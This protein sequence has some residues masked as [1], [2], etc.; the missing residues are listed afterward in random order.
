MEPPFDA[1]ASPSRVALL[2]ALLLTVS[3]AHAQAP[4][5]GHFRTYGGIDLGAPALKDITE[6]ESAVRFTDPADVKSRRAATLSDRTLEQL[7]LRN[8]AI[9]SYTKGFLRRQDFGPRAP[10]KAFAELPYLTNTQF[11]ISRRIRYDERD[12]KQ[13]GW[14]AYL[15][16][17][18]ATDTC[19][20]FNAYLGDSLRFDQQVHG[21][22]C[23]PAASRSAA[24]LEREMLTLLSH[25]RFAQ[26]MNASSF[27]VSLEIPETALAAPAPAAPPTPSATAGP[28]PP[29]PAAAERL[30]A[31]KSLLDQ[32]LIT[33]SEYEAKRKAI[34]DAP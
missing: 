30:Q 11:F 6:A 17:S 5:D 12:A 18:S 32:K 13:A 27:T 31:L 9:L 29:S 21:N 15:A 34:L 14:L 28:R 26:S 1:S 20:V 3:A 25:A 10:G 19:F 7:I 22:V 16:Q 23:F 2:V 4:G 8:D 33:P 24:Q